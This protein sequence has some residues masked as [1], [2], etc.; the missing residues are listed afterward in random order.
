MSKDELTA[1]RLYTGP[2]YFKVILPFGDLTHSIP[3]LI[4]ACNLCYASYLRCPQYNAV[5]RG[6][7]SKCSMQF[8]RW[9]ASCKGNQYTTTLH[10][11]NSAIGKLSKLTITQKVY[12]GISRG[13]LPPEFWQPNEFS[14]KGGVEFAFLS[15]TTDYNVALSC[16]KPVRSYLSR[17]RLSTPTPPALPCY[18]TP[19]SAPPTAA[20][21]FH[22]TRTCFSGLQTR[23][24]VVLVWSS[25]SCKE[26]SIEEP[27]CNGSP[28]TE[29][30]FS[31]P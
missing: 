9:F 15:A 14:V 7:R 22:L 23:R 18:R 10:I 30:P 11:I 17:P 26:W 31:V 27:T 1:T 4:S 24:V 29:Q 28:C 3:T 8:A 21:R 16:A 25:R 2:C 6:V 12:R 20:L 5:L 19:G 13:V